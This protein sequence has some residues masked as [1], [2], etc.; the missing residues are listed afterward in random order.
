MRIFA[1]TL[2]MACAAAQ[3]AEPQ[4]CAGARERAAELLAELEKEVRAAPPPKSLSEHAAAALLAGD[5]K[6]A[7]WAGLKAAEAGWN[8]KTVADAG[9]YLRH[10]ERNTDALRML[11]CAYT[12]GYR[13]PYLFEALAVVHKAQGKGEEARQAIAE[14]QRLAP[15][16][17]IIE[18]EASFIETGKAPPAPQPDANDALG[19]C[20][21]ALERHSQRVLAVRKQNHRRHDRLQ[22]SDH[23]QKAFA[24]ELQIH[25]NLIKNVRDVAA[26]ARRAG[27]AIQHNV[28]I[29]QCATA[30]FM[31]AGFLL[32][33]YYWLDS[34]FELVF[35]ADA[36]GLDAQAFVRDLPCGSPGNRCD[37]RGS[38]SLSLLS[39]SAEDRRHFGREEATR[40]YWRDIEGCNAIKGDSSGCRLKARAR[41][42]AAN[43][44]LIEQWAGVRQQ[45][46]NTASRNFDNQARHVVSLAEGEVGAAR[47]FGVGLLRDL[48]KGGP[49]FPGPDGKPFDAFGFGV[50]QINSGYV[51]LLQQHLLAGG[52]VE[53][54]LQ[55]R[56]RWFVQQRAGIEGGIVVA[57]RGHDQ[58][59][60]PVMLELRME[61]LEEQYQA[62]LEHLRDRMGWGVDSRVDT[63][64]PC[65]F[66]MGGLALKADLSDLGES[67][68]SYKATRGSYSGSVEVGPDGPRFSGS[69][70]G[71]IRGVGV[72]FDSSGKVS[73]KGGYGPFAGKGDVSFTTATNPW[74]NR[75]YLGVRLRGSAGFGAGSKGGGASAS[76]Y[77]SSGEVTIYP[78]ALLEDLGSYFAAKR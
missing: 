50:Q 30:Y 68:F 59:C 73:A 14:A 72:G 12:L 48:R 55:E 57:K 35:W 3:A 69:A 20:I 77:P 5:L 56:G 34:G 22:N 65:D 76:C 2:W 10:L 19:R 70:T 74:N 61:Q 15:G 37:D 25:Q 13:S 78:R 41:E 52:K 67:K 4:G 27:D 38:P 44:A 1:L 21:A 64:F 9:I 46:V 45:R 23:R 32:D 53:Q 40:Q 17:P 39:R 51:M 71:K 36:L 58:M 62:Y 26:N 54:F 33:S 11:N 47:E 42:C 28:A 18:A 49:S 29:G 16:D 7:A 66:S 75:E 8:G 31:L 60:E 43:K 24:G 6:L 63:R